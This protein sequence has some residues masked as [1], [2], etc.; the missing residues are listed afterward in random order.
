MVITTILWP[1]FSATRQEVKTKQHTKM[2]EARAIGLFLS[3]P[4]TGVMDTN[5]IATRTFG[6]LA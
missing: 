3:Q 6:I 5:I 2:K 1:R 4:R